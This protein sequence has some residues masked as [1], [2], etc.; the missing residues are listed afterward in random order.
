[1]GDKVAV[2]NVAMAVVVPADTAVI[3]AEN[4]AIEVLICA[5]DKVDTDSAVGLSAPIIV[6]IGSKGDSELEANCGSIVGA[7]MLSMYALKG[8]RYSAGIFSL[9]TS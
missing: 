4:P 7:E 2:C 1:M 8:S 9:I 6:P 5:I 3:D